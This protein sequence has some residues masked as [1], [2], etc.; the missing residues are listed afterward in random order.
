M[1]GG[2]PLSSF[3][4]AGPF[5]RLPFVFCLLTSGA[6]QWYCNRVALKQMFAT[7]EPSKN[8]EQAFRFGY[9]A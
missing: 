7:D 4:L 8:R 2:W 9:S 3:R 5:V 6:L 1:K